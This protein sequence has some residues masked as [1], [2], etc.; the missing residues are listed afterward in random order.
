[1]DPL[2]QESENDLSLKLKV[3]RY[4]EVQWGTYRKFL[5]TRIIEKTTKEK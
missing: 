4:L 1:M 2:Y 3:D 5:A